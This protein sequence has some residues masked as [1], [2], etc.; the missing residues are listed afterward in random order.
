MGGTEVPTT[1]VIFMKPWSSIAYNP[2]HLPLSSVKFHQ[3]DHE[4]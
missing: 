2:T 1:P 3:I 4:L